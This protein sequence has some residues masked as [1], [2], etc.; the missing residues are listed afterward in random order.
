[1][2][3]RHF[4]KGALYGTGGTLVALSGVGTAMG[5]L[6]PRRAAAAVQESENT[7]Y[8]SCEM[9]RNQCPVAIHVN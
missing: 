6:T 7:V 2:K 9:C 3:R 4:L 8:S 5:P 1:M